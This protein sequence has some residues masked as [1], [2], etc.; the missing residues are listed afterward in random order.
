MSTTVT[1]KGQTIAT[2]DNDTKTL[3]TAGKWVEGDISLTDTSVHPSGTQTY[4]ANG[5]Y[6]VT[7][8]AQAVVDVSGGTGEW[9]SIGVANA[10]EPNGAITINGAIAAYGLYGRTGITSISGVTAIGTYGL[11]GCTSLASVDLT[12]ITGSF[13]QYCLANCTSLTS[14]TSDTTANVYAYIIA[15]SGVEEVNLPYSGSVGNVSAQGNAFRNCPKLK[16]VFMSRSAMNAGTSY[17][18]TP[19]DFCRNSPLL[20]VADIG[21]LAAN[22]WKSMFTD[23]PNLR[24]IIARGTARVPTLSA[25]SLAAFGGVYSN[26]TESTIYVPS[27]LISSYQ[28]ATNWASAYAAGVTFAPIEG[29]IYEL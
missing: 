27:A 19:G 11:Y 20:E 28:T 18:N 10:S 12:N 24:T 6:D 9:T 23:C 2:V 15:N 14:I 1:Y 26:P 13:S 16:R 21:W 29:S 25:W 17:Q 4:T 8:L 22:Q 3:T 5:T 7:A